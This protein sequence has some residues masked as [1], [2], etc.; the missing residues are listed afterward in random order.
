MFRIAFSAALSAGVAA[1]AAEFVSSVADYQPGTGVGAFVNSS[2]AVGSPAPLTGQSIG[3]PN[4]LSPFS[5][6]FGSDEIVGIGLNGLLQ[7]D[8]AVPVSNVAGPDFG[9]ITNLGLADISFP[10]GVNSNPASTF[11]APRQAEVA[12]SGDGT[13]FIS[14]GLVTFDAPANYF[15]NASNPF[16]SST[17]SPAVLAD[18]GKPFA[19][20]LSTF[21]GLDWQQTLAALDGSGGGTWLDFSAT[22]LPSIKS[23]RFSIGATAP[24]GTDGKLFVDAVVA[25]NAAVPEPAAAG[26]LV[27][28]IGVLLRRR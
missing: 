21:D 14:L 15:A 23:V 22:G 6:A 9:V 26:M 11:S 3:F 7:L 8:F 18:F 25:N 1:H 16:L 19:G 5:P 13:Q 28:A 27:G 12:V 24:V 2:A 17:P 4:I 10:N 20:S